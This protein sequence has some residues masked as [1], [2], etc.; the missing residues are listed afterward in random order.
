MECQ[1]RKKG[2]KS[3]QIEVS[4]KH[5]KV[6]HAR[7][8]FLVGTREGN[9][10]Q[11]T[12]NDAERGTVMKGNAETPLKFKTVPVTMGKTAK[13]YRLDQGL[14]SIRSS[15]PPPRLANALLKITSTRIRPDFYSE[16]DNMVPTLTPL[17]P[18]VLHWEGH[19]LL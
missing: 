11:N 13:G 15:T 2:G 5:A 9:R 4:N 16:T 10:P 6:P 1:V 12:I 14:Q 18:S 8:V 3:G 17:Q 7:P 19:R